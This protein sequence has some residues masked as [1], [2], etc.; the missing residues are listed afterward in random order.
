MCMVIY[1]PSFRTKEQAKRG[2]NST[3]EIRN[4]YGYIY[5]PSFRTKEQAKRGDNSIEE[6]RNL[7]DYIFLV[8][9]P[10]SKQKGE[11]TPLKRS[12]RRPE[13]TTP[14]RLRKRNASGFIKIIFICFLK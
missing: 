10:K 12:Q 5:I 8:S 2:D 1:I 9:E 13:T 3:E 7:N 11:T 14:Y 6:I 4:L